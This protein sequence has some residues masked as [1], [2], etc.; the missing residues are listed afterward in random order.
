MRCAAGRGRAVVCCTIPH[1]FLR[2]LFF[3]STIH[4]LRPTLLLFAWIPLSS[5]SCCA[6]GNVARLAPRPLPP[7]QPRTAAAAATT[8]R[9]SPAGTRAGGGCPHYGARGGVGWGREVL[10]ACGADGRRGP[11]PHADAS[12]HSGAARTREWHWGRHRRP[13]RNQT[14]G[15]ARTPTKI[16][17][18]AAHPLAPQRGGGVDANAL[19]VRQNKRGGGRGCVQHH[20]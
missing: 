4:G 14:Q 20:T 19:G 13:T 9:Q 10:G 15:G 2:F 16:A 5:A 8:A 1:A 11:P 18:P 6:T 7:F 17:H 12:N 3:S